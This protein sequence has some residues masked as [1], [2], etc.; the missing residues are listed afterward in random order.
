MG[1]IHCHWGQFVL[2]MSWQLLAFLLWATSVGLSRGKEAVWRRKKKA[3]IRVPAVLEM[4][5]L[6]KTRRHADSSVAL[7]N[8]LKQKKQNFS[9]HG[10]N[11]WFQMQRIFEP[12][13]VSRVWNHWN[14]TMP[15]LWLSSLAA[16]WESWQAEAQWQRCF[17]WNDFCLHPSSP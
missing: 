16:G 4:F 13:P 6:P 8:M 17:S 5:E 12:F 3:R 10:H 11:T 1:L 9:I 14:C 15:W 2:T 7:W